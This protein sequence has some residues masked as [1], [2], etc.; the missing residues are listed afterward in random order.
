VTET[1]VIDASAVLATL[2][3]GGA[4]IDTIADRISSARLH[5]PDHLP[6]EVT[7]VLRRRRNAG[8]LSDGEAGVALE[9]F[10]RL[11]THLWPLESISDRVWELGHNLTSY[12]A[13]YVA[14]AEQLDVSLLTADVRLSLASGPR[15][16]IEVLN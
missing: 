8:T 14:I 11:S 5:A 12:D 6:I 13:A 4:S 15:C 2:I 7:N 3:V 9:G 16:R 10:Q 1:L